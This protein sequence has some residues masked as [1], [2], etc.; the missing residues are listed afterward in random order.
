MTP[1][2]DLTFKSEEENNTRKI[3]TINFIRFTKLEKLKDMLDYGC[4]TL[5]IKL[6]LRQVIKNFI[7]D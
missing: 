5:T 6:Q 3:F 1:M 7:G 4:I 2:F